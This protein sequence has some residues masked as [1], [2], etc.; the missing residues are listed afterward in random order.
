MMTA[1]SGVQAD[2][3]SSN[4]IEENKMLNDQVTQLHE[5]LRNKKVGKQSV[6]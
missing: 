1:D 6:S 2:L 5:Q 3:I 4:L